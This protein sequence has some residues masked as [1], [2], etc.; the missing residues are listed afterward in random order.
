MSSIFIG[1][2]DHY[3]I[4]LRS[5]FYQTLTSSHDSRWL[6]LFSLV[7]FMVLLRVSESSVT[8]F[9]LFLLAY[10]GEIAFYE[11]QLHFYCWSLSSP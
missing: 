5:T 9:C 8:G 10:D 1:R 7:Y 3:N 2:I 11:H 6:D 4:S